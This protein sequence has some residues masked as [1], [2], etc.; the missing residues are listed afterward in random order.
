MVFE[1]PVTF[2]AT[3]AAIVLGSKLTLAADG[4]GVTDVTTSGVATVVD[5]L[6]ANVAKQAGD[7][8]LVIFE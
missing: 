1:A 3:P 5:T 8:V 2:S 7:K 4:C 6:T